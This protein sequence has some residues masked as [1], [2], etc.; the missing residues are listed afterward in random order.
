MMT[1]LY[2]HMYIW[3]RMCVGINESVCLRLWIIAI[4]MYVCM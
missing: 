1:I 4:C 2:I 3:V